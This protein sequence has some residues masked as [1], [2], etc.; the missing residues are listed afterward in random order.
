[1]AKDFIVNFSN[2]VVNLDDYIWELGQPIDA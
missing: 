2:A 1:M